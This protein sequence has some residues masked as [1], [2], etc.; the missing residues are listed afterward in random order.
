M[1]SYITVLHAS[2]TLVVYQGSIHQNRT[3]EAFS[4]TRHVKGGIKN[5]QQLLA[6]SSLDD[7]WR[8]VLPERFFRCRSMSRGS[9]EW[10]SQHKELQEAVASSTGYRLGTAPHNQ[11]H[12]PIE[13][14]CTTISTR[15]SE[16]N[17]LQMR[18]LRQETA[19][20]LLYRNRTNET[21]TNTAAADGT[22]KK[23]TSETTYLTVAKPYGL[24]W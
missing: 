6:P 3:R 16:H 1:H 2:I 24:K 22:V 19:H 20:R 8:T 9:T 12:L 11:F 15:S 4:R 18:P 13:W 10:R 23:T 14:T 7:P 17:Q 5:S 21:T